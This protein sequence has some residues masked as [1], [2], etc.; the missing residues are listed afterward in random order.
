M[1][2]LKGPDSQPLEIDL[3]GRTDSVK[4]ALRNTFD[5]VP[6]QPVSSFHLEFFGGKRGLVE[7]S[8]N[9]CKHRYRAEV[10]MEGPE[11]QGA[12]TP[13]RRWG[14]AASAAIRSTATN[15]RANH[16]GPHDKILTS[17]AD[18]CACRPPSG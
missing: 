15:G 17:V 10:Q 7:L 6:D 14:T 2:K 3:V 11:R 4:G 13:N 5:A 18:A 12:S 9:L 1:V 16:D 8:R